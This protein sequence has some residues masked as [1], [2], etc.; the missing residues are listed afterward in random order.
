[1]DKTSDHSEAFAHMQYHD[2]D[3]AS[4]FGARAKPKLSE[5]ALSVTTPRITVVTPS[6]NQGHFLEQTIQSALSQDYPNLEYLVIDGGSTDN[7]VEIITKYADRISYWASEKDKGQSDAINKG[8]RRATGDVLAW[9]NSDDLYCPGALARV[10]QFFQEHPEC[11]AVIGDQESIDKDGRVIDLKKAVPVTFRRIL[12]SACAVPQ[13][14][15]FFTRRA[16]EITGDVDT[17]LHY[18]LDYDYFLRMQARGIR[19]GLIKSP[20]ARFRLHADSKTVSEY[21]RSFWA[22]LDRK[23]VV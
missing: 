20:L 23:S 9:L 12:Y 16:W 7:S 15:T 21:Q 10:A 6:Y 22:D 3:H 2:S 18:V 11:G 5:H 14:S 17:A 19:F 13:P 1:V 8:F 4:P